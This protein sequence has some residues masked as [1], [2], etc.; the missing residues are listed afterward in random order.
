MHGDVVL[1][2]EIC[3]QKGQSHMPVRLEQDV[4]DNHTTLVFRTFSVDDSGVLKQH[5]GDD[6]TPSVFQKFTLDGT[7]T[8]RSCLKRYADTK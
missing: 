1:D 7:V 8:K 6:E 5:A 4:R 2:A 3:T